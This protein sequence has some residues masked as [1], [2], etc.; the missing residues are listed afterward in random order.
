MESTK[1]RKCTM[2]ESNVLTAI[3]QG[4]QISHSREQDSGDIRTHLFKINV[5]PKASMFYT[6]PKLD[7][8]G[9]QVMDKTANLQWPSLPRVCNP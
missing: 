4:L 7:K 8:D 2:L 3:C 6:E 9:K 1:A 5:D